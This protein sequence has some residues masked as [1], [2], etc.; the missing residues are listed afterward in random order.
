MTEEDANRKLQVR[1]SEI[2]TSKMK[3]KTLVKERCGVDF[4]THH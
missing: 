1:I 4:E 3:R 2:E